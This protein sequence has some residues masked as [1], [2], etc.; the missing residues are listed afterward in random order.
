MQPHPDLDLLTSRGFE[1]FVPISQLHRGGCQDVPDVPGVYVV[2]RTEDGPPTF[3][4]RSHA[5]AW[6]G[7]DPTRPVDELEARWVAGARVL[8]IAAAP[9][10]GVR[11]RLLQRIKRYLRHG[12][13]ASVGHWDG[14]FLWQL[15]GTSRVEMAWRPCAEGEDARALADETMRAFETLH[16]ARPFA[17]ASPGGAEVTGDED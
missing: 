9:G 2:V 6:R 3:L 15:S 5:P 12:H 1:G 11:H 14:R 8:F 4:K 13:G 16:G 10:S 17:N 7:E